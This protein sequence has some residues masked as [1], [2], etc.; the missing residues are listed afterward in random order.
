MVPKT[1]LLANRKWRVLF[2]K[3]DDSGDCD[4]DGAIIRINRSLITADPELLAHTFEHELHHALFAMHG[5]HP[6]QHDERLIDGLSAL[7]RQFELT[8]RGKW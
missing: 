5:I 4:S 2:D 6:D 7:R 3:L 1:F 8:R